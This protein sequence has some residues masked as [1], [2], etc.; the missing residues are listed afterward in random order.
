MP[1]SNEAM[2]LQIPK[3]STYKEQTTS[4]LGPTLCLTKYHRAFLLVI[5]LRSQR[6]N[7]EAL[8]KKITLLKLPTT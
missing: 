6:R 3:A 1:P 4:A 5:G 8:R 2:I 7:I